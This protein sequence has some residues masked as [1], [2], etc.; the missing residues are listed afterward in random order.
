MKPNP[1]ADETQL[2][3]DWRVLCEDI[4]ERRAGSAAERRA[5]DF[6]AGRCAELGLAPVSVEEFACASLKR[7]RS[8]VQARV[9]GRWR[10][11]ESQTL[12]GAPGT[13]G[14]RACEGEIVWLEMPEDVPQLRRGSLRGKIAAVVGP[15]PTRVEDHCALVA[16][17][18]MAVIH[19]DERLPFPWAKSDGVYPAWVKRHSMPPV[20]TVPYTDAWR[21]RQAGVRRLRVGVAVE[22]RAARSQNVIAE[23][24]GRRSSSRRITTPS[25]AIPAPTTTPRASS[26]CWRSLA[27][28]RRCRGGARFASS[29]SAARS[30]CPSAPPP[31][32]V[33][34]ARWSAASGSW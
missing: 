20:V 5:A 33:R 25:A 10:T 24:P 8:R 31:T 16:A 4:G 3:R 34:I 14:G 32:S 6:I 9:G 1:A 11:V 28:W 7:A 27:C 18:P 13:P 19:V 29:H 30:S 15:L 22:L 21:W 12:V 2:L 23:L 26:S 17:N